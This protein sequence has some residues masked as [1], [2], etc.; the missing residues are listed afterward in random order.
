MSALRVTGQPLSQ[1]PLGAGHVSMH[2]MTEGGSSK[3]GFEKGIGSKQALRMGNSSICFRIPRG[4]VRERV[5]PA[6]VLVRFI[7]IYV[8]M[9]T[10][11]I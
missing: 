8:Q 1:G 6:M 3:I 7:S 10:G 9:L 2:T 11:P 4:R 5:E